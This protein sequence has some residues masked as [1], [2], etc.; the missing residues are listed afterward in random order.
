M[1]TPPS[2]ISRRLDIALAAGREAGEAT[3]RYFQRHGLAIE[4]KGDGSPVTEADKLA[5]KIIRR[6]IAAAFPADA[7]LGEEEGETPGRSGY[8]WI[9]DPIDGTRPFS[10]GIP[11]FG[12]LIAVERAPAHASACAP[13]VVG[14]AHFP[15]LYELHWGAL[16]LGAWWQTPR[17]GPQRMRVSPVSSL[18]DAVVDTLSHQSWA[19]SERMDAFE[20]LAQATRRLRSWSDAYSLALVATGRVEAGVDFGAKIWDVAPFGIILPEAGGRMSCFSGSD[21]LTTGT[22]IASNGPLH[23]PLLGILAPSAASASMGAGLRA[24]G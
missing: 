7:I 10:R 2:D 18:A 9:L 8:R 15:A 5:E 13:M 16:G 1:T 17:A 12:N 21:S 6:H 20:R 24:A 3:L 23:A 11:T 14:V 19:K 22:Y 4:F